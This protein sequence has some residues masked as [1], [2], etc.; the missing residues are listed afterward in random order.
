[1]KPPLTQTYTLSH[2][3]IATNITSAKPNGIS[4]KSFYEHKRSIKRNDDRNALF[5]H[6]LELKHTFK[7]SQATLIKHIHRKKSCKL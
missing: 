3:K 6:M 7:F 5:S 2:A 1:M 4:K